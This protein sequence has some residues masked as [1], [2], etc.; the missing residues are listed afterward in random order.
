MRR[1]YL[2]G[3]AVGGFLARHNLHLDAVRQRLDD[4]FSEVDA[5]MRDG[6]AKV[7]RP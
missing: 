3:L 7:R 2:I 5:G 1:A 6:L 4:L